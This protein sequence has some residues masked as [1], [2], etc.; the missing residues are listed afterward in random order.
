MAQLLAAYFLSVTSIKELGDDAEARA[1]G[2]SRRR[3]GHERLGQKGDMKKK[4]KSSASE[5][6]LINIHI[7]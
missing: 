3:F 2:A 5:M 4:K 7:N 1:M 6:Q